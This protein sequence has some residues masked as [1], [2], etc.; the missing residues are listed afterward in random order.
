M[1]ELSPKMQRAIRVALHGL[2]PTWLEETLRAVAREEGLEAER[3]GTTINMFFIGNN[4]LGD[5]MSKKDQH[6]DQFAD[7]SSG[8]TMA[9]SFGTES[10]A[11]SHGNL[12][13]QSGLRSQDFAQLA[14]LF[15]EL[16]QILTTAQVPNRK[17]LDEAVDTL[18][19][20]KSATEAPAPEKG[21]VIA[22]WDKVRS[23]VTSAIDV[24]LFVE[25]T[26]EKIKH[27]VGKIGGLIS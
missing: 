23:W 16:A 25:T 20:A 21:R 24:G 3:S 1:A 12:I 15:E 17:K 26:A 22:A 5:L 4:H 10:K 19:E 2:D 18:G 9:K 27:L 11:E 7:L 14:L 6:G 13:Q 8:P